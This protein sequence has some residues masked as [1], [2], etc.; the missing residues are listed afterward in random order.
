MF[1]ADDPLSFE[2]YQEFAI[3]TASPETLA[4]ESSMLCAAALG[5]AGESGEFCDH[6]KKSFFQ[7]HTADKAHLKK[8]IGDILWYCALAAQALDTSLEDIA[9]DNVLKLQKRYPEGFEVKRS[10]HRE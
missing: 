1:T 7:G 3:L 9:K 10:L 2:D 5:L 8:E 6:I 4:N